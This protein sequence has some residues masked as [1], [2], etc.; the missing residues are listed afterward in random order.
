[1]DC[2]ELHSRWLLTGFETPG[3]LRGITCTLGG[4]VAELKE[5][6]LYWRTGRIGTDGTTSRRAEPAS[7]VRDDI[8]IR[9]RR[10]RMTYSGGSRGSLARARCL[11]LDDMPVGCI[12]YVGSQR[13]E[14]LLPS[15]PR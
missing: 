4:A 10:A 15:R 2:W 5:R 13:I 6:Q 9:G 1:M 14:C 12:Q 11:R 8:Y 3:L 7:R